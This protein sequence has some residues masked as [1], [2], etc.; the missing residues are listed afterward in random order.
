MKF[1]KKKWKLGN[2]V[3]FFFTIVDANTK[4]N[5]RSSPEKPLSDLGQISYRSYWSRCLLEELKLIQAEGAQ[6]IS[7]MD[8][9]LRTALKNDDIISTLEYLGILKESVKDDLST[10]FYDLTQIDAAIAKL[11]P[12]NAPKIKPELIHWS[13]LKVNV[14]RDKWSM[15]SKSLKKVR[16]ESNA[17]TSGN[18]L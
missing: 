3:C 7:I 13:P 16:V 6:A 18:H 5:A 9:S 15:K 14:A 8:I 4:Q 1:R 2:C 12:N 10:I 17:A 11:G